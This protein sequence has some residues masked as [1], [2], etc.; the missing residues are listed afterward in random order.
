MD[1]PLSASI[2]TAHGYN[3]NFRSEVTLKY[4]PADARSLP[5]AGV[6][7]RMPRV[8]PRHPD[9]EDEG[10]LMEIRRCPGKLH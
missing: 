3:V 4:V 8:V 7:Q 6:P 2:Q 10:A 1:S 9:S 5:I